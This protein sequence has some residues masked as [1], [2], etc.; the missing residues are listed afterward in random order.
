MRWVTKAEAI[1]AKSNHTVKMMLNKEHHKKMVNWTKPNVNRDFKSQSVRNTLL[2]TVSEEVEKAAFWRPEEC[3]SGGQTICLQAIPALK[4]CH[5]V[6]ECVRG[7]VPKEAN[8][9]STIWAKGLARKPPWTMLKPKS[10][11]VSKIMM[12][13]RN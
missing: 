1:R 5:D 3:E 9:A 4:S 13:R 6:L 7:S 11:K 12:T 8:L 10:P 2:I